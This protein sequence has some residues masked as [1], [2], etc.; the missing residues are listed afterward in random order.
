[1]LKILNK[2]IFK[3]SFTIEQKKI[4]KRQRELISMLYAY[5]LADACIHF[6]CEINE[7]YVNSDRVKNMG[8]S[9]YLLAF[10]P[11]THFSEIWRTSL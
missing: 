10:K 11:L 7:C 8:W 1:M 5:L 9:T 3:I 2:W 6:L 4:I